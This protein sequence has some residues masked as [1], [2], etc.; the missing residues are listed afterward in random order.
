MP[1]RRRAEA[2]ASLIASV[3]SATLMICAR[4][5]PRAGVM[6][7][8]MMLK[9]ASLSVASP[10]SAT[11]LVLPTSTTVIVFGSAM[12]WRWR[13]EQSTIGVEESLISNL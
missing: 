11:T 6:P 13:L 7:T 3:A 4:R 10:T 9:P 5:T 12:F 1:A 2:S 8:P